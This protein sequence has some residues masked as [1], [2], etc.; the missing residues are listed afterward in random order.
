MPPNSMLVLRAR[1]KGVQIY[2]C[3]RVPDDA[4]A[5]DWKLKA[6]EAEL[7][8]DRGEKVAHHFAGPTW[9]AM[10]GSSVVGN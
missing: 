6:P 10:D 9:Q 8:D 5:F 2:E 7:F 4:R 1:A 3:A